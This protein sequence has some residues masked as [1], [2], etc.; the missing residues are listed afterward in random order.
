MMQN[1]M[2]FYEEPRL[3]T[4]Y[5]F[6]ARP[7]RWAGSLFTLILKENNDIRRNVRSLQISMRDCH[8]HLWTI[9]LILKRHVCNVYVP[10]RVV[11]MLDTVKGSVGLWLGY[12][13][14]RVWIHSER[15][16]NVVMNMIILM[17]INIW[18]LFSTSIGIDTLQWSVLLCFEYNRIQ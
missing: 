11:D 17:Y 5:A 6:V 2:D 4:S 1:S 14:D 13:R 9:T 12:A 3:K 15:V 16:C 8:I 18:I 7:S 10:V